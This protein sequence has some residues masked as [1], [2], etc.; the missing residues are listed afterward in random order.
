M[1]WVHGPNLGGS[2]TPKANCGELEP[3][4]G[5]L[6]IVKL[7]LIKYWQNLKLPCV[8]KV[9]TAHPQ[10]AHGSWVAIFQFIKVEVGGG[11]GSPSVPRGSNP[12]LRSVQRSVWV[13]AKGYPPSFW[14]S[15]WSLQKANSF[16]GCIFFGKKAGIQILRHVEWFEWLPLLGKWLN[17]YFFREVADWLFSKNSECPDF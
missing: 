6:G 13:W 4:W 11:G 17:G 2:D 1:N 15:H 3:G 16:I 5:A 8:Q 12:P 14:Y 7:I 9:T 10:L